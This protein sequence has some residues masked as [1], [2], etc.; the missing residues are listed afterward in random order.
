[1]KIAVTVNG[2]RSSFFLKAF[3]SYIDIGTYAVRD[4]A[5]MTTNKNKLII[6]CILQCRYQLLKTA[7]LKK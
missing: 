1:M 6:V 7:K 4:G 5:C 3:R 2:Q